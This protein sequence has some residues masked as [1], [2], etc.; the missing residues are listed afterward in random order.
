M[1][2]DAVIKIIG[3]PRDSNSDRAHH[4]SFYLQQSSPDDRALYLYV[5]TLPTYVESKSDNLA[6]VG[7][8]LA[9]YGLWQGI[10][11]LPLGIAA[12]WLGRRKPF[13]IAGFALSGLGALMMGISGDVNGLVIGRAITGLAAGT[14]VPLVAV[15]SGLFL[16]HEAVKA[17]AILSEFLVGEGFNGGRIDD[18][19][20]FLQCFIDEIIGD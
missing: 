19:A 4:F 20:I 6:L 10:I 15:F 2:R 16:P 14:W 7:V 1:G 13:I 18:F 9:Q 12:D 17:T 11:R 8:V 3:R 5:P